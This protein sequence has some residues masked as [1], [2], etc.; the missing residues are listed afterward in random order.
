MACDQVKAWL[1]QAG[2]AFVA[3]NVEEDG[4]A[5]DALLAT[6]FRTVPLTKIGDR[7]VKG[8][9]PDALAEALSVWPGPV[10]PTAP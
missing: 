8:F 2:V 9:A 10:D 5:Y 7:F 1:S 4:A 6:G 3:H